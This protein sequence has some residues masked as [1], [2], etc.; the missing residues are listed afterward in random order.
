MGVCADTPSRA[1]TVSPVLFLSR[2]TASAVSPKP[3]AGSPRYSTAQANLL[4]TLSKRFGSPEQSFISRREL[5]VRVNATPIS[6]TA[7]ARSSTLSL[8][9]LDFTPS[10]KRISAKPYFFTS[11]S[12]PSNMPSIAP[13]V[14][15]V[16]SVSNPQ[17]T[18]AIVACIKSVWSIMLAIIKPMF[19]RQSVASA[20]PY[21]LTIFSRTAATLPHSSHHRTES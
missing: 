9:K 2:N 12:A 10:L 21:S 7:L 4:E 13:T 19:C 16:Q 11:E 15:A 8:S 6:A 1:Q 18:A 5:T 14:A 3:I 20:L 17:F